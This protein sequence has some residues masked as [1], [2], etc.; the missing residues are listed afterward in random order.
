MS[1]AA[2]DSAPFAMVSRTVRRI[3]AAIL[4]STMRLA[5]VNCWYSAV[6]DTVIEAVRIWII[7]LLLDQQ[8]QFRRD[9]HD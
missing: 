1:V 4:G 5:S 9:A 2:T 8:Y 3:G 6:R 7:S